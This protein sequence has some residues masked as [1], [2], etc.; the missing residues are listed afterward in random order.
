MA[1][2]VSRGQG[3]VRLEGRL[4][5]WRAGRAPVIRPA[6]GLLVMLGT[7][8]GGSGLERAAGGLAGGGAHFA[9]GYL[10]AAP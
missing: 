9:C 2:P 1:S 7:T 5:G 4:E 10:G 3:Q 6:P 8:R